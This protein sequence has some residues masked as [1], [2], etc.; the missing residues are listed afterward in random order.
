VGDD[1]NDV[2]MME[3]ARLSI[4]FNGRLKARDYAD[5]SIESNDLRDVIPHIKRHVNGNHGSSYPKT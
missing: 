1:A 3:G 5:V 4:S 2:D